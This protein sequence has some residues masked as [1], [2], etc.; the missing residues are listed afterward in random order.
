MRWR[1][2]GESESSQFT[3]SACLTASWSR[4]ASES[5][6]VYIAS[7]SFANFS[8][9]LRREFLKVLVNR[10]FLEKGYETKDLISWKTSAFYDRR[11]RK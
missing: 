11:T 8:A 4:S 5:T 9:R 2:G 10:P 1:G 7:I 3:R 6:W